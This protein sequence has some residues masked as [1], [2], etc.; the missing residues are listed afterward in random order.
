ME[1]HSEDKLK[2]MVVKGA[3][4]GGKLVNM[5]S[6]EQHPRKVLCFAQKFLGAPL[7]STVGWTLLDNLVPLDL[8]HISGGQS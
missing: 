2:L 3:A 5:S 8:Y 4:E 6:H 7:I 1:S